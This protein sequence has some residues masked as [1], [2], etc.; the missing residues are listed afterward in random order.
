MS[1]FVRPAAT[2]EYPSGDGQPMT[3]NDWQLLAIINSVSALHYHF[4][5][6]PDRLRVR[7]PLHL[8][9]GGQSARPGGAGRVRRV[10][11]AESQASHLQAVG[12]GGGARLRDGSRVGQHVAARTT[13]ARRSS[14]SGSGCRSTGSTTRRGS[15]SGC[16]SRAV[17]WWKARTCR[18]R[19]WESIDGTL[20]LRSETLGL[21]FRVKGGGV[22]LLRPREG[23]APSQP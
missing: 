10:R 21:D 3:E 12:G 23:R 8:L 9:R 6:R 19:W 16:V 18:R 1:R 2:V 15:I 14:T 4:R 11:G 22:A 5:D 17:A 13:G 7:G 20:L